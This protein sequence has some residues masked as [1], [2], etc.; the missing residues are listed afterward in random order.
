MAR[1]IEELGGQY[2]AALSRQVTHLVA[3][4][5]FN[6]PKYLSACKLGIAILRREFVEECWTRAHLSS[7]DLSLL[8]ERFRAPLFLGVLASVSGLGIEDRKEAEGLL[9]TNGGE[10]CGDFTDRCTH[11]LVEEGLDEGVRGR[12]KVAYAAIAKIPIV[13]RSWL[14]ESVAKGIC[15]SETGFLVEIKPEGKDGGRPTQSFLYDDLTIEEISR[16]EVPA[17]FEGLH[18]WLD[19]AHQRMALLKRLIL[20]AGGTR[21]SGQL[22]KESA[23]L[24]T[25]FVVAQQTVTEA[26]LKLLERWDVLG[27]GRL[28]IVHEQWLFACF[29]ERRLL[30][31]GSFSID[32]SKF[33]PPKGE[34]KALSQG[35]KNFAT[36]RTS[37]GKERRIVPCRSQP[38]LASRSRLSLTCPS[39]ESEE[40]IPPK[41][42]QRGSTLPVFAGLT[43]SV[44]IENDLHKTTLIDLIERH[45]GIS[46]EEPSADFLIVPLLVASPP[47]PKMRTEFWLEQC[48]ASL[49]LLP[50]GAS[51]A[52]R[53]LFPMKQFDHRMV[54]TVTGFQGIERDYYGRLLALLGMQFSENLTK[55]HTHLLCKSL[56][57]NGPKYDFAVK[58]GTIAIVSVDWLLA[59]ITGPV[60]SAEGEN[61]R[62]EAENLR[63]GED[64]GGVGTPTR[65]KVAK[66]LLKAVSS[67]P[68]TGLSQAVVSKAS[69]LLPPLRGLTI[70]ISQRLWHRRDELHDLVTSLG[71]SFA[72]SWDDS[73][74]HYLHQGNQPEETF[75]EFRL[76]QRSKGFIVSPLWLAACQEQKRRMSELDFPHTLKSL[77]VPSQEIKTAFGV[78]LGAFGQ[79]PDDFKVDESAYALELNNKRKKPTVRFLSD[80]EAASLKKETAKKVIMVSGL[81]GAAKSKAIASLDKLLGENDRVE[82]SQGWHPG[83]THLIVGTSLSRTEKVLAGCA[84]GCWILRPEWIAASEA[85]GRLLDEAPF[86]Y[87]TSTSTSTSDESQDKALLKAPQKWRLARERTGKKAFHEW[88][89]LLVADQKRLP[90]L[91]AVLEAGSA[92]VSL[93]KDCLAQKEGQEWTHVLV[94]SP[95]M[96]SR[97]PKEIGD[98]MKKA[99]GI[100]SVELIAQHLIGDLNS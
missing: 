11:L 99:G 94:S 68:A 42:Q 93:L 5:T 12:P 23:G 59:E 61:V 29:Y 97:L 92:R 63:R 3:K 78:T 22:S 20:A 64:N 100:Q 81:A 76:V 17:Y 15:L 47:N 89:V 56:P 91:T 36:G 55:K 1:R 26:D 25:H 14:Y 57:G 73:C 33:W 9:K 6:S 44:Q 40:P 32:L 67:I 98:R 58:T 53:P 48:V 90:G 66:A 19:E 50:L 39:E 62:E 35:V 49:K 65:E 82:Q 86:E 10:Y 60:P 69:E 13:R 54:I 4:R 7:V 45:G 85:A 2:S 24:L 18:F 70:A 83:T 46:S 43:L 51:P 8:V 21:H 30:A 75:R 71:G 28:K 79:V 84:G 34:A 52:Y 31:L 95:Q 80:E 72:W 77:P 27:E 38:I 16:V 74:S 96:K 88:N 87:T 41:E 37:L